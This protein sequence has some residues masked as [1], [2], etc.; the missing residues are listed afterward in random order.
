MSKRWDRTFFFATLIL[1]V[2]SVG[3]AQIIGTMNMR[4]GSGS[5]GGGGSASLSDEQ[6]RTFAGLLE[7][8]GMS[9]SVLE[10]SIV[11]GQV[12]ATRAELAEVRE[13]ARRYQRIF[14]LEAL[15]NPNVAHRLIRDDVLP[16][17]EGSA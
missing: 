4:S 16:I 12:P 13:I 3:S 8:V 14:P 17:A 1:A 11:S 5:A 15:T 2:A 10:A 7:V 6:I 9:A